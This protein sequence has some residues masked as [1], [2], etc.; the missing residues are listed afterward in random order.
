MR[1]RISDS[2]V[3]EGAH[4]PASTGGYRGCPQFWWDS[5]DQ[6]RR[7]GSAGKR[8]NEQPDCYSRGL[9]MPKALAKVVISFG[10]ESANVVPTKF[11]Y[12]RHHN[13]CLREPFPGV[14]ITIISQETGHQ[15]DGNK[16]RCRKLSLTGLV[17]FLVLRPAAA[18]RTTSSPPMAARRSHPALTVYHLRKSSLS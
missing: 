7:R 16:R 17:R 14:Q 5:G 8:W 6:L 18:M 3:D 15:P 12:H 1:R 13:G 9:T 4:V 11:Q 10:S 2:P